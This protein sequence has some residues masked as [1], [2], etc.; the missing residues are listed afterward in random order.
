[1]KYMHVPFYRLNFVYLKESST[2]F[3]ED[4]ILLFDD[5]YVDNTRE[6]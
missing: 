4:C 2:F 6:V 5:K 3:I 1:M